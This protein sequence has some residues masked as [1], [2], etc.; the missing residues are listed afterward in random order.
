[1]TSI[2]KRPRYFLDMDLEVRNRV[3]ALAALQ[4]KT[5]KEWLTE[6]VVAKMEDEIDAA[7]GLASLADFEGTKTLE[8]YLEKRNKKTDKSK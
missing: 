3:K 7:E 8:Q 4:G 2:A 6:A 1:M 5:M